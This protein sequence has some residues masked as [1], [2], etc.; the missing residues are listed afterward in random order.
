MEHL[1]FCE[2]ASI[3]EVVESVSKLRHARA[4]ERTRSVLRADD[5]GSLQ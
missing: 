5:S 4:I 3:L 1:T 2:I